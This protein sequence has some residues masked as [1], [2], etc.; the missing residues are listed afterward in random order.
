MKWLLAID[1]T[2]DVQGLINYVHTKHTKNKV[3]I[4]ANPR[5][6]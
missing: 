5:N 1:Y 2:A 3:E 6:R 4:K